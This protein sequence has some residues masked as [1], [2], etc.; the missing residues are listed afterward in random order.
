MCTPVLADRDVSDLLTNA[1]FLWLVGALV[2]TL[3][4]GAVALSW[5]ERWRKRQL[6][7]TPAADIEQISTYRQMYERGELSK[8]E[9]DR[10]RAREAQRLKARLGAKPPAAPAAAPPPAPPAVEPPAQ[11]SPQEP[12]PPA[13][14]T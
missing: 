11:P 13:P 10:I 2:G 1:E 9:Y 4:A 14:P 7:D 3:L 12:S 5:V 8:E 6:S